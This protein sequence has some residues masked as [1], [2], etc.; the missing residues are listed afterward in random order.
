MLVNRR[1]GESFV[2][3]KSLIVLEKGELC[4]TGIIPV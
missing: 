3:R 1:L 2:M 4:V